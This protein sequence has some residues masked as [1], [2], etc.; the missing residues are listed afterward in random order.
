MQVRGVRVEVVLE[1]LDQVHVLLDDYLFDVDFAPQVVPPVTFSG[2]QRASKQNK[3][4]SYNYDTRISL[5]H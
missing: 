1:V 2:C 4:P 3:I 5:F